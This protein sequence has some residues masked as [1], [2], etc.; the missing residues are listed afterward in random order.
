LV[1]GDEFRYRPRNP[2]ATITANPIKHAIAAD[3]SCRAATADLRGAASKH[4]IP[5]TKNTISNAKLIR[6]TTVVLCFG[7]ACAAIREAH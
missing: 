3:R 2:S 7:K 4:V 6:A 5:A 1:L